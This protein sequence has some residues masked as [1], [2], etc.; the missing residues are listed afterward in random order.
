MALATVHK[1]PFDRLPEEI[2]L[3]ILLFAMESDIPFF[4]KYYLKARHHAQSERSK[5]VRPTPR[6]FQSPTQVGHLADWLLINSTSSRIRRL[7][8]EAFFKAKI[9]AMTN[10][11]AERLQTG[12]VLDLVS[13]NDRSLALEYT[14]DLV[15]VRN[16]ISSPVELVWIAKRLQ[17]FPRLKSFTLLFGDQHGKRTELAARAVVG[18]AETAGRFKMPED[19]RQLFLD[20]GVPKHL[21]LQV[22]VCPGTTWSAERSTLV[23]NIYPV[24]IY[25]AKE[26]ARK[27]KEENQKK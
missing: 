26:L 22:A 11:L 21:D 7:G 5:R 9:I 8:K 4:L 23:Q 2:L 20:N 17:A 27:H 3:S 16:K 25:R 12:A 1:S 14:S 18:T 19:L 13:Q 24:L 10:T 15:F 6:K